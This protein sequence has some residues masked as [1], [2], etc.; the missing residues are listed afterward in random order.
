MSIEEMKQQVL[1]SYKNMKVEK[2]FLFM[3]VNSEKSATLMK[4]FIEYHFSSLDVVVRPLYSDWIHWI[5]GIHDAWEIK[6]HVADVVNDNFM[7]KKKTKADLSLEEIELIEHMAGISFKDLQDQVQKVVMVSDKIQDK[8]GVFWKI[9]P[10]SQYHIYSTMVSLSYSC[11]CLRRIYN[12]D[13]YS[14]LSY[15]TEKKTKDVEV[16]VSFY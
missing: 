7:Y 14:S 6:L 12:D 15:S 8:L 1:N 9:M 5:I 13:C 16:F 3:T 11:I 2:P 4:N 10:I